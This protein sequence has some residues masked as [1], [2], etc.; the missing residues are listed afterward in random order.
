VSANDELAA[1]ASDLR[2]VLEKLPDLSALSVQKLPAIRALLQGEPARLGDDAGV[3]VSRVL[4]PRG[5][6]NDGVPALLYQPAAT[7]GVRCPAVLNIH[8]GGYVAGAAQR[9]DAAMRELARNLS[10]V[11]VTPD[12]RLAPESPFPAALEDCDAALGW[13]HREAS[14]LGVDEQ[15]VTVRGTSA[16]GGIALGLALLARDRK[17]PPICFLQL[18]YPMLDDR[19][20]EHPFTGKY[21]WP[22]AS[23]QF[24]WDALLRGQDRANP[25]PYAV[26]GRAENLAGLPPIFLAVGSIDLF[27]GEILSLATRLVDAGVSVELHMYPGAYHGFAL[28]ADS[29]VAKSFH[30]DSTAALRRVMHEA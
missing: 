22:V 2:V 7:A 23:N 8:G 29:C 25:S 28:V 12:Y 3:T 16:G 21:V 27:A 30:R 24:G 6:G 18:V 15:C 5:Q 19:T 9:E 17:D 20:S 10:C 14:A 1:V 11:V 4:V 26:P 13:L